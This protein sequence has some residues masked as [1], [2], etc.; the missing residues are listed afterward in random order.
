[1]AL[2][3]CLRMSSGRIPVRSLAGRG[4]G[5]EPAT[6]PAMISERMLEARRGRP[7][8]SQQL[9]RTA[10]VAHE[11]EPDVRDFVSM[12]RVASDCRYAVEC[13]SEGGAKKPGQLVTEEGLYGRRGGRTYLPGAG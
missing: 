2:W 7:G 8:Q 3:F 9:A 4:G 5:G 10:N 11:R 6:W 1:M 13:G 12:G